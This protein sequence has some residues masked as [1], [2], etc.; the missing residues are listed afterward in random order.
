MKIQSSVPTRRWLWWAETGR[1]TIGKFRLIL[2][3]SSFLAIDQNFS[4]PWSQQ[5]KKD[6]GGQ[7]VRPKIRRKP[8]ELIQ[9]VI[10]REKPLAIEFGGIFKLPNFSSFS[11]ES[12]PCRHS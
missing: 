11:A 8:P 5:Y 9:D 6:V 10:E 7:Q 3:K 2:L 1:R 12:A 4:A